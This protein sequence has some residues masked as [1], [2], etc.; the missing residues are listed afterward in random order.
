MSDATPPG[1][2]TPPSNPAPVSAVNTGPAMTPGEVQDGKVF[3]ILGY[4]LNFVGVPFWLLP[5]I[6]RNNDFSLYHGKQCMMLWLACL[7]GYT[8]G[9]VLTFVCVGFFIIAAVAVASLV[10][11]IIGLLNAVNS[12]AVPLPVIGKYG[13]E[14]FSGLRK[15]G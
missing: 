1:M 9:G 7:I 5:I 10:F 4:A 8:A 14:W 11:N 2:N 6:L 3:A 13:E 12:K 15:A